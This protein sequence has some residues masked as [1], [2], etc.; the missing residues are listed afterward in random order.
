MEIGLSSTFLPSCFGLMTT[1]PRSVTMTPAGS[2][3]ELIGPVRG[4]FDAVG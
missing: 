2:S 4:D 1:P 3:T